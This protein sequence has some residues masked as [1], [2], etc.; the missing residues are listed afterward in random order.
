MIE[1]DKYKII[2][3]RMKIEN[4]WKLLGINFIGNWVKIPCGKLPIF[5]KFTVDAA[6]NSYRTKLCR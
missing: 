4:Y 1:T 3:L 6:P 2:V 5:P